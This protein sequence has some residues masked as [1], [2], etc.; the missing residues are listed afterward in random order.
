MQ[1]IESGRLGGRY[2][3]RLPKG[4]PGLRP[5]AAR[6]RGAV[7]DRIGSE[8]RGAR[9]LDLFGGSGAMSVEAISRGAQKATVVELS[10]KVARHLRTQAEALGITEQL[11]V[12]KADA[13]E[14]LQRGGS[15]YDLV[16]IDPPFA[17]PEVVDG[18]AERI[19]QGWLAEGAIVVCERELVRGKSREVAWPESLELEAT[20]HYGQAVVEF[21]RFAPKTESLHADDL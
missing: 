3:L 21:L 12:V 6:V 18:I 17:I 4:V 11:Q 1:R 16:I 7:F 19:V 9:V 20:K 10:G 8:V 14:F 13:L 5:T 2:L 15:A